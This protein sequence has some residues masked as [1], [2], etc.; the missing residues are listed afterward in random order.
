MLDMFKRPTDPPEYNQLYAIPGAA[1]LA[2]Y[3]AGHFTGA[4]A[5]SCACCVAA[6]PL[7]RPWRRHARMG[8]LYGWLISIRLLWLL[9]PPL[10]GHAEME[11]L[12]YLGSGS[13]CI[14]AIACLANQQTARLGGCERAVTGAGS[15]AGLGGAG[16]RERQAHWWSAGGGGVAGGGGGGACAVQ[17]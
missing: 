12:A 11:S 7:L 13:L 2:V 14:A 17:R 5:C 3:A 4:C 9:F 16:R 10:A 1:M 8:W 6:A 15:R